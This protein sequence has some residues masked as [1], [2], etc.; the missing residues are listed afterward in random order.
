[1]LRLEKWKDKRIVCYFREK[2]VKF[3][4]KRIGNWLKRENSRKKLIINI[5]MLECV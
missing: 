2:L 4:M 1:M 5:Y 3:K